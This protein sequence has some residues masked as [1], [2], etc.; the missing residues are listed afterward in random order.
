[1]YSPMYD[2]PQTIETVRAWFLEA[3]FDDVV[4]AYGPNGVVG[5][6]RRPRQPY[7]VGRRA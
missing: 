1:M 2:N 4:V 6:G 5:R 3:G 7:D